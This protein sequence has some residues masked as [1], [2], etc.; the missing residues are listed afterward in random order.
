MKPAWKESFEMYDDYEQEEEEDTFGAVSDSYQ[1]DRPD[2][3]ELAERILGYSHSNENLLELIQNGDDKKMEIALN[4]LLKRYDPM[5]QKTI[6]QAGAR[7][8]SD[9]ED[10]YSEF[11]VRLTQAL[12][13]NR[14]KDVEHPIAWL[15][16][17]ARNATIDYLRREGRYERVIQLAPNDEDSDVFEAEAFEQF[18]TTLGIHVE[19]SSESEVIQRERID[20]IKAEI[21]KL[22]LI[23]REV[24]YLLIQ[25]HQRKVI[26]DLLEIEEGT[27]DSRIGK[28]RKKLAHLRE[29][30]DDE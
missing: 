8:D 27:V 14:W 26:A 19:A 21:K 4:T 2:F 23:Y 29:D 7:N 18:L 24:I 16:T 28:I 6:Y 15:E 11:S 17:V 13:K 20:Y 25:G 3:E 10:A 12:N 1:A 22:P 5:I 30:E 9:K